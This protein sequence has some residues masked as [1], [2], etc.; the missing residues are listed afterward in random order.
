MRTALLL[1]GLIFLSFQAQGQEDGQ[2]Q[3]M[4]PAELYGYVIAQQVG[5]DELGF[6]EEE[7]QLFLKG[8]Q[9]G[10]AGGGMAAVQDQLPGLQE[11]LQGRATEAQEKMAAEVAEQEAVFVEDLQN[12]PDVIADPSGFYYE[13]IEPGDD[14]RA[15][16]ADS[17]VVNYEGTLVDGT[18]FDSSY[19]RG[20]PATFPMNGVIPGFSGGLSKIGQGGE[21]KIYIPAELGY[22]DNPDPRSGIPPGAMIVFDAELLE[23]VPAE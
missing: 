18:V 13:I 8:M 15:S 20:E 9:T 1:S 14:V 16:E 23:V 21:I 3:E 12:D 17:V 6:S 4:S 19:Q 22:G 2:S 10:L 5:L 7:K 11:F